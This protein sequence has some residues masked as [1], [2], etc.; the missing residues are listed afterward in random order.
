MWSNSILSCIL[1][2]HKI[3]LLYS[4]LC[5]K[6][7]SYYFF[8]IMCIIRLIIYSFHF[9]I[10]KH[11]KIFVIK[12]G[13]MSDRLETHLEDI[14]SSCSVLNTVIIFQNSCLGDAEFIHAY[15][16]LFLGYFRCF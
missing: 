5:C 9:R 3:I 7:P 8:E 16:R 2:D 10:V 1:F 11:D 4:P 12:G 13:M 15:F 6:K 14:S